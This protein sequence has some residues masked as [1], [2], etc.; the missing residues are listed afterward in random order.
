MEIME[1]FCRVAVRGLLRSSNFHLPGVPADEILK[2][3]SIVVCVALYVAL[4]LLI[5]SNIIARYNAKLLTIGRYTVT[6]TRLLLPPIHVCHLLGYS[7]IG[8][9]DTEWWFIGESFRN[10]ADLDPH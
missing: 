10:C 9:I 1:S 3:N 7:A 2:Q 5:Y 8:Q 6:I 4:S